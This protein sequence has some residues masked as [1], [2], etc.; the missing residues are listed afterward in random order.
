MTGGIDLSALQNL[1][2]NSDINQTTGEN[3]FIQKFGYNSDINQTIGGLST[4]LRLLRLSYE[5]EFGGNI[6]GFG[7][8]S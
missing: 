2:R 4:K 8:F 5:W 7:I 1:Q 3:S 6:I